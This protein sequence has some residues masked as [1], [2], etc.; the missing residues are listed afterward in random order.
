MGHSFKVNFSAFIIVILLTC[1]TECYQYSKTLC[2][3]EKGFIDLLFVLF[4]LKT[5]IHWLS[6]RRSCPSASCP[7]AYRHD[8][9]ADKRH[10][11][12]NRET[13]IHV[14]NV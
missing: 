1:L 9:R 10:C 3:R 5:V 6:A 11:R 8:R 12:H 4:L 7:S 13:D 2:Y 14:F